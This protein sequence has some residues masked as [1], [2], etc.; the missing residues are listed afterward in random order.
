MKQA[1]YSKRPQS[2]SSD[3]HR[4]H[5]KQTNGDFGEGKMRGNPQQSVEKYLTLARD[6]ASSGDP[7]SAENYYQYADHYYRLSLANRISR[8]S[9]PPEKRSERGETQSPPSET[10]SEGATP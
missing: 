9:P 4:P 2:R 7:V 5:Q 10:P 8:Y 3:R 1:G 6:A